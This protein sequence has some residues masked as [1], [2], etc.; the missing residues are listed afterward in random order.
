MK[1]Q[2]TTSY[3]ISSGSGLYS[4]NLAKNLASWLG[5]LPPLTLKRVSIFLNTHP[6][7]GISL[8]SVLV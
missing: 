4:K 5:S 6:F 2:H 1:C 3:I 7:F 8:V